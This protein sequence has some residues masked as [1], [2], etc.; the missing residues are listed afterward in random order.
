MGASRDMPSRLLRGGQREGKRIQST[1]YS[2]TCEKSLSVSE[3]CPSLRRA[4]P[5]AVPTMSQKPHIHLEGRGPHLR[6]FL[7]GAQSSAIRAEDAA[8]FPLLTLEQQGQGAGNGPGLEVAQCPPQT[9]P[10]R[11]I[12]RMGLGFPEGAWDRAP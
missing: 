10:N 12:E 2:A 7:G 4:N 8:R 11:N 9:P 3:A 5:F 1:E 6:S